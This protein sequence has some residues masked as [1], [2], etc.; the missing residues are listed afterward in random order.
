MNIIGNQQSNVNFFHNNNGDNLKLLPPKSLKLNPEVKPEKK[1]KFLIF[2][3]FTSL[4]L[5]F[6][7]LE[8]LNTSILMIT[9]FLIFIF[10]T[11]SKT[12]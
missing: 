11:F 3:L 10:Q 12:F 8:Y 1:F 9:A 2:W 7:Q 6:E 5:W 4:S